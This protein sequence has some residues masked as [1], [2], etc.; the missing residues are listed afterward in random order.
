MHFLFIDTGY[1]LNEAVI[2]IYATVKHMLNIFTNNY[3][4]LLQMCF[5]NILS[6]EPYGNKY[7]LW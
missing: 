3:K 1:L 6:L 7:I 2:E 5:F 4:L